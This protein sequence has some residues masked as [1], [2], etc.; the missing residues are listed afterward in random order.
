MCFSNYMEQAVGEG[1]SRQRLSCLWW[2]LRLLPAC[3][4]CGMWN[5]HGYCLRNRQT[6]QTL[7]DVIDGFCASGRQLLAFSCSGPC[8][9]TAPTTAARHVC[10]NFLRK[11]GFCDLMRSFGSSRNM[12]PVCC[13]PVG[14]G[15][16]R[17]TGIVGSAVT[18]A[19]LTWTASISSRFRCATASFSSAVCQVLKL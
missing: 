1:A 12:H 3:I 19:F 14:S 15:G 11:I 4:A 16:K 13:L 2:T 7:G 10:G 17:T 6:G 5:R 8:D 9:R 18:L